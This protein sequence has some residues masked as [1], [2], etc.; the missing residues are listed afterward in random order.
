MKKKLTLTI[1]EEVY[2]GIKDL[3]RRVSISE[4][5]S[6]ILRLLVEG[7]KGKT[8]EEA[9]R[10]LLSDAST[11]EAFEYLSDNLKPYFRAEDELKAKLKKGLKVKRSRKK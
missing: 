2:E 11:K 7:L 9:R 4:S 6:I 10:V 8:P 3:P 5:V 1:D